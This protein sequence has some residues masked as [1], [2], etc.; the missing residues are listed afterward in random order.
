MNGKPA[1]DAPQLWGW[2]VAAGV[3]LVA[4][5]VSYA[6]IGMSSAGGVAVGTVLFL[7][8]GFI[9]GFERKPTPL[10]E[11]GTAGRPEGDTRA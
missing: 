6:A 3:A 11:P 8:V 9:L 1:K 4:F 5:G 2:A 7:V 10:K